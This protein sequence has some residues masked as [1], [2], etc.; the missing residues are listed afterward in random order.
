YVDEEQRMYYTKWKRDLEAQ[1]RKMFEA[2]AYKNAEKEV[3]ASVARTLAENGFDAEKIALF[4]GLSPL[5]VQ[6]ALQAKP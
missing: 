6:T 3:R 5:D 2:R 1:W 4:T